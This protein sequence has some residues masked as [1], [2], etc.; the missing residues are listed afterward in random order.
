MGKA[1]YRD[2]GPPGERL[3][4][5]AAQS[6]RVAHFDSHVGSGFPGFDKREMDSFADAN[7]RRWR[8]F[9]NDT[10][11]VAGSRCIIRYTSARKLPTSRAAAERQHLAL[12]ATPHIQQR[13]HNAASSRETDLRRISRPRPPATPFRSPTL[14]ILGPKRWIGSKE[15]VANCGNDRAAPSRR[16]Q[17]IVD[18]EHERMERHTRTLF[19]WIEGLSATASTR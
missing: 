1:S 4:G 17:T 14:D 19:V 18:H 10:A 2:C 7:L 3:C 8:G 16:Q 9:Q 12:L 11:T 13:I 5:C 15:T 6:G